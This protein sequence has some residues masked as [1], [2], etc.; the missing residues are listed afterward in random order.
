MNMVQTSPEAQCR[1]NLEPG[2]TLCIVQGVSKKVVKHIHMD[3][4]PI[5][6]PISDFATVM[7]SPLYLVKQGAEYTELG[8]RA[9]GKK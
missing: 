8:L 5:G 2:F 4:N 1:K 6:R 9:G 7:P 3:L